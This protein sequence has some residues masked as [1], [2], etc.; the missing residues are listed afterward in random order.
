MADVR[1][2]R[3]VVDWVGRNQDF[4]RAS[5]RNA[6][7]LRAQ[8]RRIQR[9][10]RE[11]REFN[12]TA[13][14]MVRRL[15]L[16][17]GIA[18]G[19]AARSFAQFEQSMAK[20]RGITNATDRQFQYLEKTALRLGR[21]TRFS[22]GQV[23][24]GSLFLA[25][26]GQ[27]PRQIEQT[28]PGALRLAQGAD[29]EV[30]VAADIVTNQLAAFRENVDQT[31]RFVDVLT[32]RHQ[33]RQHRSDSACR[34]YEIRRARRPRAFGLDIETTAA[35]VGVLSNAGLQGTLAGTGLRRVMVGLAAP[36]K[37]ASDILAR[38]G[39]TLQDVSVRQHGL[40]PVIDRLA[41]AGLSA[42][43]AFQIF[44]QRGFG[45]FDVLSGRVDQLRQLTAQF[46]DVAGV[47][48][49]LAD[50]M[51]DTLTGAFFRAISAAE[52]FSIQLLRVTGAADAIRSGLEGT[53]NILNNFTDGLADSADVV[54]LTGKI[55]F[56][57]L[58]VSRFRAVSL[59]ADQV[60]AS[61][62]SIRFH[63]V[64]R[65]RRR[66]GIVATGFVLARR[67]VRGFGGALRSID[68]RAAFRATRY[69][70]LARGIDAVSRSA[71]I[72]TGALRTL[73]RATVVFAVAEGLIA[74]G[75][76]FHQPESQHQ[77]AGDHLQGCGGNGGP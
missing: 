20:V 4:I 31:T 34:R 77:G 59:S 32:R 24:E 45:A 36:T 8:R 64:N 11:A 48:Q 54:V 40:I 3:L 65:L 55:L 52:G 21:T 9:L 73:R 17:A 25:R 51:D 68:A 42:G 41:R 28:L 33:L 23:A 74:L 10:N 61:L 26:A 18:G 46:G 19:Y 39:F 22:A 12:Q 5:R 71:R 76:F 1:L 60:N 62:N 29:V 35:A 43:E 44:G 15:S 66:I 75:K 16:V 63:G 53:A 67:S 13:D 70:I 69:R 37:Q 14:R 7:A 2:A 57:A 49:R 38:Y 58:A 47:S 6:Q 50:I 56:A 72:A 27:N 30:G